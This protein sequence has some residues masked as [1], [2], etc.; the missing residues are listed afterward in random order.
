MESERLIQLSAEV[1]NNYLLPLIY[2]KLP[3]IKDK[4]CILLTSSPA[5]GTADKFSDLDLF[6]IFEK[7]KDYIRYKEKLE[8]L[9]KSKPLP[10]VY[11]SNIK[12]D[13]GI[14]FEFES[15]QRSD[16]SKIYYHSSNKLY[17]VLQTDWLLYWFLNSKIIYDP[18][19]IRKKLY[20]RAKFY[21]EEILTYK[22]N[23]A[24]LRIEKY[25][26]LI[27]GF[28]Q[29]KSNIYGYLTLDILFRMFNQILNI[30]YWKCKSYSPHPKWKYYLLSKHTQ[31]QAYI[32]LIQDINS[33]ILQYPSLMKAPRRLLQKINTITSH[34]HSS[35]KYTSD[36]RT[37]LDVK[38]LKELAF[39]CKLKNKDY[40]EVLLIKDMFINMEKFKLIELAINTKE[41]KIYLPDELGIHYLQNKNYNYDI[42]MRIHD[43]LRWIILNSNFKKSIP[44][45]VL[46]ESNSI[47]RKRMCYLNFVLWRKIRVIEKAIKRGQIFNKYWYST[48]VLTHFVE[49]LSRVNEKFIVPEEFLTIEFIKSI[50]FVDV[51]Q[52]YRNKNFW[53]ILKRYP[54]IFIE[55]CWEALT[56]IQKEL[57]KKGLITRECIDN[58]LKIQFDIEYWKYENLFI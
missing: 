14:R 12:L 58:P 18:N 20:E 34:L 5:Y 50:D 56:Q 11:K 30:V 15:L 43:K 36:V 31:N 28:S 29:T 27:N 9:I 13:K 44:K 41:F 55:W 7:Q 6:I 40:S 53:S 37:K 54:E 21:P 49:L 25:K 17:W 48:Q 4:V 42:A 10:N 22:I 33:V 24:L 16:I 45:Y 2:K 47:V 19:N 39:L 23:A 26:K 8:N 51:I 1:T 32:Q 46:N 57:Q 35:V 38:T 3:E 52:W